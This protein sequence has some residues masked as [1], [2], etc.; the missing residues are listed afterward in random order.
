MKIRTVHKVLLLVYII[1]YILSIALILRLGYPLWI[2][3][4]WNLVSF[5][6]A[7]FPI[8]FS[9]PDQP[10]PLAYINNIFGVLGN[11]ILIIL[12]TSFFYQVLSEINLKETFI[13]YKIGKLKNHII[14][15][16]ANKMALYVAQ[17][18]KQNNINFVIL[19]PSKKNVEE[20]L[21]EKLLATIGEG[22]DMLALDIAGA[23]HASTIVLLNEEGIKNALAAISARKLNNKI[24]IA[25]RVKSPDEIAKIKRVGVNYIIMP[26]FA[27]GNEISNFVLKYTKG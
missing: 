22:S 10:N 7:D 15:T 27:I 14:I 12:L 4:V 17:Q 26:E 21:D 8:N 20:C 23:K 16:P 13:N 25:S 5:V 18:L 19:D 24:R 2:A 3:L 9:I 6:G 1:L 11:L